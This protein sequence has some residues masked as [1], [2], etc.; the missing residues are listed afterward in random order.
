MLVALALLSSARSF[1]IDLLVYTNSDSGPGSLRQVISDNNT[2]GGGNN[3]IF[4]NAVTGT[5]TLTSGQLVISKDLILIGPGANVLTVSGNNASR[6]FFITNATVSISGLTVSAGTNALGGGIYNQAST[7]TISNCNISSNSASDG[8]GIL[9]DGESSGKAT[10]TID[11]CTFSRNV[12]IGSVAF[13]NGIGGGIVNS[14]DQGGGTAMTISNC[15]FSGNS[16][17]D[18]GCIFNSDAALTVIGSTFGGNFASD[19]GGNIYQVDISPSGGVAILKI[20]DTIF[21]NSF[22]TRGGSIVNESG[23]VTSLG[24]NLSDDG[25]GGFLTGTADQINTD[26][27]LGPLQDNGGTT[28]T[29]EPLA[30]SPA[31]DQGKSFGLATDQRGQP[32][33]YDNP[34]ISNASDGSDIGAVEVGPPAALVVS[35]NNDSGAGSLR[36]AVLNVNMDESGTITFAPN[37]TGAITLTSGQLMISHNLALIGPGA[38]VLAVSGNHANRVFDITNAS[39]VT[40]FG[41]TVS[42]GTS[43]GGG[44]GIYNDHSMLTISNCTLS[45]NSALAGGGI[46][47]NGESSG[48]ATLTVIR[49]TFSGNSAANPDSSGGG[50]IFNDGLLGIATLTISNCTFNGNSANPQGGGIYNDGALSG[51]TPATLT[52][53]ASTFS[54]NSAVGNCGGIYNDGFNAVTKIGDTILNAGFP[55]ANIANNNGGTI[56]SVGYNLSSDGGGGFLINTADQ[57]NTDPKLGP[58]QDNGG[59]TFTQ[60]LLSNSPAIDK[61]KSLG[62][63]TDQRGAPRPFD[64]SSIANASG[65]DGSDIGAFELG[66]PTLNIQQVN[67]NVVL[68]WQSFYG[69]FTLQSVTNILAS[70]SWATVTGTRA[71]V[72]NQYVLTNGMVSGNWFYRLKGN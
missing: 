2:L 30:G 41:L 39:T 23:I 38:N 7:L 19:A 1:A 51:S 12:A 22:S 25:F 29:M 8:G 13:G 68:S 69:D 70:N 31:L 21:N 49:S 26:A 34:A 47:N 3:I 28:P 14:G 46:Y 66:R 50:G 72:A 71:V 15:T 65:G 33:T 6:V 27:K 59:P 35:N 16:A 62:V 11:N 45:G 55:G 36:Q 64:F 10:M 37:V 18:A 63:T 48:E 24:Y 67:T 40:I 4:S 58:L 53:I 42:A 9:N 60:A 43:A 61:G 56:T 44:G 52:V 57:I 54:G 20:G 5:I 17:V 32:R